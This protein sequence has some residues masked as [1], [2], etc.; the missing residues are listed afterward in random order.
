MVT[1]L[2]TAMSETGVC[3]AVALTVGAISHGS[4]HLAESIRHYR[5]AR[6]V[7]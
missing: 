1:T 4:D 2:I 5:K 3:A 6:H 7:R